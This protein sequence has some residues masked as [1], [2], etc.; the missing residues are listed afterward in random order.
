MQLK[1]YQREALDDL[2]DY[3]DLARAGDTA[4]AWDAATAAAR[5]RALERGRVVGH[6][7]Y[8]PLPGMEQIPYVCIRLP[9]GGGKTLLAAET[10]PL[11]RTFLGRDRP[12][13][14]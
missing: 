1:T 5:T 13:V 10:I 9:T 2:R 14:L 11:A 12:L 7:A 8:E 3:L 4:A 6:A